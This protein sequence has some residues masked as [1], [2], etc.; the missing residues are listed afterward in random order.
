MHEN[1]YKKM[2]RKKLQIPPGPSVDHMGISSCQHFWLEPE[3]MLWLQEERWVARDLFI[4]LLLSTSDFRN[5]RIGTASMAYTGFRGNHRN[6]IPRS[7]LSDWKLH[8]IPQR[9]SF[10]GRRRHDLI[11]PGEGQP[12]LEEAREGSHR[13]PAEEEGRAKGGGGCRVGT[14]AITLLRLGAYRNERQK[15]DDSML[16]EAGRGR[17]WPG[18]GLWAQSPVMAVLHPP[19]HWAWKRRGRWWPL[20]STRQYLGCHPRRGRPLQEPPTV[21]LWASASGGRM[22]F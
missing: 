22:L 6:Q 5:L 11:P 9:L 18:E 10:M 15:Q 16:W 12:I 3:T 4:H 1:I 19:N 21:F 13:G 20:P 14:P 8:W 17:E 7:K 2:P